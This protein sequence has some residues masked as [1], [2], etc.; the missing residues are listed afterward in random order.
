M[1]SL[2]KSDVVIGKMVNI[3]MRDGEKGVSLKLIDETFR[4]LKVKHEIKDPL[5]LIHRAVDNAKPL[6]ALI[7]HYPHG[8]K[9]AV[10]IPLKPE[11]QLGKALRFIKQAVADRKEHYGHV[12][13]ANELVELAN[14]QG[15][16]KKRRDDLHRLAE[17]NRAYAHYRWR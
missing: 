7:P 3:F 11:Q 15:G 9:V 2:Y 4:E 12:R 6:V 10:P 14:G 16:A 13:L 5:S 17:Q 8:K 1:S